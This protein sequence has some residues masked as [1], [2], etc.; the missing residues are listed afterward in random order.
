MMDVAAPLL[1]IGQFFGRIGCIF[2]KC[3]YGNLVTSKAL[4]WFP[5][6]IKVH[7]E[8]HYATNFYESLLNL[9][10]FFGLTV[11]LRKI[12]IKGFNTCAYLVGY[13][14]VRFILEMFRAE[15]QT[16][17][18]GSYPVSQLLS[19]I[20]LIGGTIGITTLLIVNHQ[21]RQKETNNE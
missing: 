11:L 18:I 13:G 14:L 16:L 10:L 20:L 2:G 8:Y 21:R 7:G 6:A 15:E 4:Q 17:Y 12:N 3:C 19:L 5:I 1:S 9:G